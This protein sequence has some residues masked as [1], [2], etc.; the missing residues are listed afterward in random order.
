M[1]RTGAAMM[2]PALFAVGCA[3]VKEI[4]GG[5]RDTA[6]PQLVASLPAQASTGYQGD[7]IILQFDER[8]VLERPG[9]RVLIS[10]PLEALPT[11]NA[12]S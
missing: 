2:L 11:Y 3:Q 12:P 5:E 1:N 9:D 8:V 4:A 10:P 6:A 7:R